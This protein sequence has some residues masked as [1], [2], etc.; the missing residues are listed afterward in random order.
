MLHEYQKDDRS[1]KQKQYIS[2]FQTFNP[3]QPTEE[4]D[5]GKYQHPLKWKR[6]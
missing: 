2:W 3:S 6:W 4:M 5:K 1:L